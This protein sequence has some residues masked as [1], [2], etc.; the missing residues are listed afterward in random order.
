MDSKAFHFHGNPSLVVL[1]Y[2]ALVDDVT[3]DRPKPFIFILVFSKEHISA[4]KI[5]MHNTET[6]QV[7]LILDTNQMQ[8]GIIEVFI[9]R[10]LHMNT[11]M[12]LIC[13]WLICRLCTTLHT[14]CCG[15]V[16]SIIM[17]TMPQHKHVNRYMYMYTNLQCSPQ[18]RPLL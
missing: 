7:L 6:G 1:T 3:R 17:D 13:I 9:C 8:M 11:S 18:I 2:T 5:V 12:I 16:E 14:Q 10:R 15:T 4:C